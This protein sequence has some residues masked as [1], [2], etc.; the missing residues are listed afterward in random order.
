MKAQNQIE[1]I[2][3]YGN[4]VLIDYDKQQIIFPDESLTQ[5]ELENIACYLSEEGFT[6][7]ARLNSNN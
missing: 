4:T 6:E 5:E 7:K 1:E 3:V 2:N